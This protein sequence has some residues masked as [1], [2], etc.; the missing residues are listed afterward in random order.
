MCIRDSGMARVWIAL[1]LGCFTP[2]AHCTT[3][4]VTSS[5]NPGGDGSS[6]N[7]FDTLSAAVADGADSIILGSGTFNL[8]TTTISGGSRSI[9]G[10]GSSVLSTTAPGAHL[11]IRGA[12]TVALTDLRFLNGSGVNGGAIQSTEGST[13]TVERC[14]FDANLASQSGGAIFAD[15]GSV[16]VL[17]SAFRN[18]KVR[19]N[20][21]EAEAY[22]GA[23]AMVGA[24]FGTIVVNTSEF[25]NNTVTSPVGSLGGGIAAHGA[26]APLHVHQCSFRYNTA[27]YGG[28]VSVS[29]SPAS[30]VLHNVTFD[31]N[32]AED[33]A[34][35]DHSPAYGGAAHFRNSTAALTHAQFSSNQ[36]ET[37]GGLLARSSS[38]VACSS[39]T[40]TSNRALKF[41]GGVASQ[42]S[43]RLSLSGCSV[44]NGTALKGGGVYVQK[45]AYTCTDTN[46]SSNTASET[47]GFMYLV[48]TTSV[49]VS[50][51]TVTANMATSGVG[52]GALYSDT[53]H[54]GAVKFAG[55]TFSANQA[56]AGPGGAVVLYG[57]WSTNYEFDRC[58]LS[59]NTALQRGGAMALWSTRGVISRSTF[60]RNVVGAAE[61]GSAVYMAA[62]STMGIREDS[63]FR[64]HLD[65]T[66]SPVLAIEN[67]S[68]VLSATTFTRNAGQGSVV[69]VIEGANPSFEFSYFTHNT[70]LSSAPSAALLLNG[71]GNTTLTNCTFSDNRSPGGP[72]LIVGVRASAVLRGCTLE[73]NVGTNG[74]ALMV[75]STLA[76]VLVQSSRML[77]NSAS[78]HGGAIYLS[79]GAR[80]SVLDSQFTNNTA[81]SEGGAVFA[82]VSAAVQVQHSGFTLNRAGFGGGLS[83]SEGAKQ[84]SSWPM[85]ADSSFNANHAEYAGGASFWHIGAPT[86]TLQTCT[87]CTY[88][89]NTVGQAGYGPDHAS[90]ISSVAYPNSSQHAFV[91]GV[92]SDEASFYLD[93]LDR[94]S[95]RVVSPAGSGV[96]CALNWGSTVNQFAGDTVRYS[97]RGVVTFPAVRIAAAVD[98]SVPNSFNCTYARCSPADSSVFQRAVDVSGTV[99]V[100][101]CQVGQYK[102]METVLV[103]DAS[104]GLKNL[105]ETGRVK[106]CLSCPRGKFSQELGVSEC[107]AC[108]L[109]AVCPGGDQLVPKEG[110]WKPNP[111]YGSVYKCSKDGCLGGA[112][113]TC[114]SGYHGKVC[115]VCDAKH[116][117]FA[118]SCQDC[119]AGNGGLILYIPVGSLVFCL[120][121]GGYLSRESKKDAKAKHFFISCYKQ[122]LHGMAMTAVSFCQVLALIVFTISGVPWPD[123]F[124]SFVAVL[125]FSQLNL[126]DILPLECYLDHLTFYH[127]LICSF[128]FPLTVLLYNGVYLW[129]ELRQHPMPVGEVTAS[130]T[131]EMNE[132]ERSAHSPR[133]ST[134]TDYD[135]EE[136]T[137]T[138]DDSDSDEY[139]DS[140]SDGESPTVSTQVKDTRS[141]PQKQRDSIIGDRLKCVLVWSFALYPGTCSQ[142]LHVFFCREIDGAEWLVADVT[143]QCFGAQW[144]PWA[145]FSGAM[146]LV[147]L[148]GLPLSSMLWL[149]LNKARHTDHSFQRRYGT[150]YTMYRP[151]QWY[152]LSTDCLRKLLMVGVIVFFSPGSVTQT[153]MAF[154]M[155][156]FFT[157]YHIKF[158]PYMDAAVNRMQLISEST[159]AATLFSG[160][161]LQ[162][163]LC[164]DEGGVSAMIMTVFLIMSNLC[165]G[166][167]IVW[168][169][170][171]YLFKQSKDIQGTR[172]AVMAWD[173]MVVGGGWRQWRLLFLSDS[174]ESDQDTT[175][176][177]N[178]SAE[179][180]DDSDE[181]LE[182]DSTH[183]MFG[184]AVAAAA[185]P[186]AFKSDEAP[187][188]EKHNVGASNCS[189][190]APSNEFSKQDPEPISKRHGRSLQDIIQA[191]NS[192]NASTAGGAECRQ[193]LSQKQSDEVQGGHRDALPSELSMFDQSASSSH[194][195]IDGNESDVSAPLTPRRRRASQRRGKGEDDGP[196]IQI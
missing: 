82:G 170:G 117:A 28:A 13:V 64:N 180:S 114:K 144:S 21:L 59:G 70:G 36:A 106:N 191:R 136:V 100:R 109:G 14:Q 32:R 141:A 17:S 162:A 73:K 2:T 192:R 72:A 66:G 161:G 46:Y 179:D 91:P 168:L 110:Y 165:A 154:I 130:V 112:N 12:A 33:V 23:I 145:T 38:Q 4:H 57:D 196:G 40:F 55:T 53:A 126:F 63:I 19:S 194:A 76:A 27:L 68:P 175:Y 116:A 8:G 29:S 187:E 135:S 25:S 119:S 152:A 189:A 79:T 125:R 113:S 181:S 156:Y 92:P 193:G 35:G 80:C 93:V 77:H 127:S 178:S 171:Q 142:A 143:Q 10:S 24:S 131:T 101:V 37:G 99:K 102:D 39:C 167:M 54:A 153:A 137:E 129:L 190:V 174:L 58:T 41:G 67:A 81:T 108:P 107:Q 6:G 74:G 83:F 52:G 195:G 7:P 11:N 188:Y 123:E 5:A 15:S 62:G 9:K 140:D 169:I 160:L 48:H 185:N 121:V 49:L 44:S 164:K 30:N 184:H 42:S 186:L 157:M 18:N 150:L 134:H 90:D 98:S 89:S 45:A 103:T 97:V 172:K 158:Q 88:S 133:E 111:G 43:S 22:G 1:L 182:F 163:H 60:E 65:S 96:Q 118:H 75:N 34:N 85:Q 148:V 71:A 26:S 159:L 177:S 139:Y 95:Q 104:T 16:T 56:P 132:L 3:V 151:E 183:G 138:F 155:A 166:V 120:L 47:A 149:K 61:L 94:F 124:R 78:G 176:S 128:G 69:A 147:F 173:Q 86:D 105:Q 20:Q 122:K 51:A 146:V 115:G 50:N 84:L 87:S 31:G